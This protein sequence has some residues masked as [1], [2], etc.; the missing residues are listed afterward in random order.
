[1]MP[2]INDLKNNIVN[3]QNEIKNKF[4]LP[5][6][7]TYSVILVIYNWDILFYLTFGNEEALNKI[8]YAKENYF[9]GN[10][11][12]IWK[13]I[14]YALFYSILFPFL[15]LLINLIV[16]FS[17]NINNKIT[18][19]EELDNATHRFNIQQ[20][21]TGSQSLEQLQIKIDQLIGENEKLINTN[22]ALLAQVKKESIEV[23]DSKS[24]FNSEYEKSAKEIFTEV[25]KLNNEEKSAFIEVLSV[26]EDAKSYIAIGSIESGTIFPKHVGK[27]LEILLKKNIVEQ[28][29]NNIAYFRV[30]SFG[31]KLI[32]Y[33]KANFVK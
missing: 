4:R 6:F 27:A 15:Q 8:N 29:P 11:S 5:I 9:Y 3:V 24:I 17:K 10:Y 25:N 18:R 33:F 31:S 30:N 7:L 13:P 28:N 23:L 26:I 22:T 32:K 12:R 19:K 20:Q 14:L 16:Q 1:M 21:L 2:E